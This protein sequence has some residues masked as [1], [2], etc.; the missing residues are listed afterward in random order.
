MTVGY[1]L[2]PRVMREYRRVLVPLAVALV[3]NLLAYILVVYPLSQRVANIAQREEAAGRELKNA[4]IQH[5]RDVQALE[6]ESESV[7]ADA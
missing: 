1:E 7:D 5:A 4:Q 6:I 2:A 3:V